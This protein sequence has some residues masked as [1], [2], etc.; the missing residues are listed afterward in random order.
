MWYVYSMT[1][2]CAIKWKEILYWTTWMN[3]EGFTI[4]EK[5]QTEKDTYC[6]ILI[7]MEYKTTT[8]KNQNHTKKRSDLWLLEVGV[9][10]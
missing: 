7:H 10:E 1:S 5:S 4:S 9:R 2:Y 6:M 3:P 8:T